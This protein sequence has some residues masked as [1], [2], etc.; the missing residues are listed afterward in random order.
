MPPLNVAGLGD[1]SFPLPPFE[2]DEAELLYLDER[3]AE[4]AARI[5]DSMQLL[6]RIHCRCNELKAPVYPPPPELLSLVSKNTCSPDILKV[7]VFRDTWDPY[8]LTN[9]PAMVMS[10]ISSLW[11][12]MALATPELWTSFALG[13]S[14]FKNHTHVPL[15][16][17]YMTRAR[18]LHV[19]VD[20]ARYTTRRPVRYL[21]LLSLRR[22]CIK[23]TLCEYD[24]HRSNGSSS[25]HNCDNCAL[26]V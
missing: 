23:L 14:P 1:G 20:S 11:R 2:S 10:S 12:Q 22:M 17:L 6:A 13:V 4:T 18:T 26:F 19:F 24:T 25:I 8:L 7:D 3:A 16:R 9:R 15:L 5:R 21:T